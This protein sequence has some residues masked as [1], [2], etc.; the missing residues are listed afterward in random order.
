MTAAVN[1]CTTRSLMGLRPS[2]RLSYGRHRQVERSATCD[3]VRDLL[4]GDTVCAMKNSPRGRTRTTYLRVYASVPSGGRD[5][6]PNTRCL[7]TGFVWTRPTLDHNYISLNKVHLV[8]VLLFLI[9]FFLRMSYFSVWYICLNIICLYF[10]YAS[11][12][13]K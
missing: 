2:W 3:F 6:F 1:H 12:I 5:N 13:V 7:K 10:M 11:V 4:D 9:F 8:N